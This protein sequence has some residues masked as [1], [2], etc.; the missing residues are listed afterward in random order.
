ML[1]A[2]MALSHDES[3]KKYIKKYAE[4]RDLFD[5]DFAKAWYALTSADM[6]PATRCI[7]DMV[8]DPQP[9]QNPL[10]DPPE[11]F[12][13]ADFVQ[14]AEAIKDKLQVQEDSEQARRYLKK[15]E[16]EEPAIDEEDMDANTL[17]QLALNCAS[18]FRA[19]DYRGGCNGARIRFPP[20]SE[21]ESNI[22]LVGHLDN[23]EQI[24]SELKD[25][26]V[27]ISMADLIVLAGNVALE[28]SN[29]DL[30]LNLDFCSGR[31]DAED[32]SGSDVLAPR[33]YSPPIITVTDDWAVKGLTPEEGVALF[34]ATSL[35]SQYYID[36]LAADYMS[37]YHEEND[38]YTPEEL[39][40]I[41]DQ[42]LKSIVEKFADDEAALLEAFTSAWTYMMT[43]DRFT[44]NRDNACTGVST[45]YKAT[46]ATSG[47]GDGDIAVVIS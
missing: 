5:A 24:K 42:D 39:A 6:G 12:A 31:V 44:N 16:Q 2:D 13:L 21:W 35:G 29:P 10:P 1:T 7:G 18:T 36:L 23:L 20:E 15:K 25:H 37:S 43:A 46:A 40:L 9:F 26:G 8:P 41:E 45:V 34:S 3:Y 33:F 11:N 14:V 30:D 22:H 19:T 17:I 27:E 32:G 38:G 4:D 47:A 28:H